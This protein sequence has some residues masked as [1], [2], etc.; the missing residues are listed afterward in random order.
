[1]IYDGDTPIYRY[2]CYA[3]GY[4]RFVSKGKEAGTYTCTGAADLLLD[5]FGN[6]S[7]LVYGTYTYDSGLVKVTT[8][9]NSYA[10][11]IDTSSM[12]YV[13]VTADEWTGPHEF[14]VS[15][16]GYY[17]NVASPAVLTVDIDS[18]EKGKAK[19]KLNMKTDW[20]DYKDVVSSLVSYSWDST[21][22]KLVLYGVIVG[23]ADGRSQE[24]VKVT[25]NVAED[26][27]S[28]SWDE[29]FYLRAASGGDNTYLNIKGLV[30]ESK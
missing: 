15:A 25:F 22:R 29:D 14:S 3:S 6:A 23:T 10:Y 28:L 26:M 21:E 17:S 18:S 13:T 19:I 5:G 1:M 7:G 8:G 30:L 27:K 4:P 20:A 11:E 2:E 12:K 24:K 16:T 9:A